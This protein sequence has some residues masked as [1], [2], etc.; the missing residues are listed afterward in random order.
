MICPR[1]NSSLAISNTYGIEIDFC[2]NCRGVWLDK[3]ELDKI[4]ERSNSDS[5]FSIN[6]NERS[7]Y[8]EHQ[9]SHHNKHD[10][11]HYS[12]HNEHGYSQHKHKKSFL[13][14]LFDF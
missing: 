7:H 3:G 12:H 10:D 1:C 13:S 11:K 6:E 8:N 5:P 4:I 14:E 9:Y 2:T